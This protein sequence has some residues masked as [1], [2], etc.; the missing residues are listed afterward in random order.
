MNQQVLFVYFLVSLFIE[1][2]YFIC[3]REMKIPRILMIPQYLVH[4]IS[5]H[6]SLHD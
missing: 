4:K 3:S 5:I 6:H 1:L 2:L